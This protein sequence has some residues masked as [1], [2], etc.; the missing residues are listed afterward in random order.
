MTDTTALLAALASYNITLGPRRP[1]GGRVITL[2]D[3]NGEPLI[4]RVIARALLVDPEGLA[5]VLDSVCRDLVITS[6]CADDTV[7]TALL[8]RD[9]IRVY[10]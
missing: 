8:S 10:A 6:G 2:H 3:A 5:E 7:R 9:R 1:D 4:Q